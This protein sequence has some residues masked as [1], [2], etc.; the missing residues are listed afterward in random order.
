MEVLPSFDAAVWIVL[1]LF[2]A[3]ALAIVPNV[4]C[5]PGGRMGP[6]VTTQSARLHGPQE[7]EIDGV[8]WKILSLEMVRLQSQK[9]MLDRLQIV[10]NWDREV[11]FESQ[12]SAEDQVW[13]L[14]RFYYQTGLYEKL[15]SNF[16][17][18]PPLQADGIWVLLTHPKYLG[19]SNNY[20]VGMSR[21]E[22]QDR[23][24]R[25]EAKQPE[26]NPRSS[27]TP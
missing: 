12:K 14:I 13:P 18:E 25:E 20:R 23:I 24:D 9:A 19:Y 15:T 6:D 11:N 1:K 21:K 27:S 3:T 22:M 17:A 5:Q 26:L 8:R 7:L 10:V 4:S 16:P 2:V